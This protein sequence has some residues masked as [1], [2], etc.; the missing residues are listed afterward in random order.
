[1]LIGGN[2][3]IGVTAPLRARLDGF[4]DLVVGLLGSVYF[5]GMLGR[6]PRGA[7]HHPARRPHPRLR[8][9]C[10]ARNA[11]FASFITDR[12]DIEIDLLHRPRGTSLDRMR[13]LCVNKV[14]VH[15]RSF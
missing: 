15:G 6:R 3:L 5:A 10:G 1:L 14:T 13:R 2:A 4:P 12:T 7:H 11:R 8:R 9:L